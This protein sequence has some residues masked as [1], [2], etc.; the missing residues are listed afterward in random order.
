MKNRVKIKEGIFFFLPRSQELL[1]REKSKRNPHKSDGHLFA[2]SLRAEDTDH[3]SVTHLS[4]DKSFQSDSG[5]QAVVAQESGDDKTTV[6]NLW[7][8]APLRLL[9]V[10]PRSASLRQ[11]LQL[12]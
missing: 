4:V 1:S 9:P 6:Y 11:L 5:S 12:N 7:S 10:P 8:W 2:E 3:P